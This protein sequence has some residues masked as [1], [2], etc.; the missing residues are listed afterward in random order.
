MCNAVGV[1]VCVCVVDE[2]EMA[3]CCSQIPGRARALSG[4]TCARGLCL[5][6]WSARSTFRL[7]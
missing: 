3:N 1:C 7:L 5:I 2:G 4:E 6:T